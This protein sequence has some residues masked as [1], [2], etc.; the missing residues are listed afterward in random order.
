MGDPP[1]KDYGRVRGG[2]DQVLSIARFL[3]GANAATEV[4]VAGWEAGSRK[5]DLRM[6]AGSMTSD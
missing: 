3:A 4:C 1:G 2:G 5:K 6:Q